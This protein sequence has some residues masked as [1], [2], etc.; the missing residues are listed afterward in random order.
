MAN[1]L[2]EYVISLTTNID[3]T[4]IQKMFSLLDSS[5]L[6]TLGVTAALAA[7]TTATYKFIESATKE[8]FRLQSLAKTQN[9]A[10][11]NVRASEEALSA[12][13]MTLNEI[14]KDKAMETIYNDLVKFN[15]EMS[16]PNMASALAKVNELRTA[17][18]KLKSA[19]SY[20]IQWVN[21][22]VLANLEEP[23]N[24]ITNKITD[25]ANWIR[26]NITKIATKVSTYITAFAKGIIGIVES[27][28][29]IVN[30]VNQIPAGIKNIMTSIGLLW[31]LIKSG[32]IGQLLTLVTMIGD[33][34]Q[35]YENYKWNQTQPEENR[36]GVAFE[37]L[38]RKLDSGDYEGIADSIIQALTKAL[39]DFTEFLS[40][41]NLDDILSDPESALSGFF[42]RITNWFNKDGATELKGLGDAFLKALGTALSFTGDVGT[43]FLSS[44]ASAFGI[45]KQEDIE[46]AF[47]KNPISTGFST[48]L[49]LS[50][51]GADPIAA[52]AGGIVSSIDKNK[53]DLGD[54]FDL[55]SDEVKAQYEGGKEQFIAEN[56]W[57]NLGINAGEL[58]EGLLGM[59]KS[60]I[61]TIDGF[62]L[63]IF[64]MIADS[65]KSD[66][67]GIL[68]SLGELISSF[69]EPIEKEVNGEVVKEA[70]TLG[71]VILNGIITSLMTGNGLAG[72]VASLA[73]LI[74]KVQTDEEWNEF[75]QECQK[76]GEAV[77]KLLF[78][79]VDE[80]TGQQRGGIVNAIVEFVS[81]LWETIGPHLEPLWEGIKNGI[82]S[83]AAGIWDL[84][85]P[86][87]SF[88]GFK[89]KGWLDDFLEKNGLIKWVAEMFGY[90][91]GGGNSWVEDEYGNVTTA[92]R[93]KQNGASD[94]EI[95]EAFK[96]GNN[97]EVVKMFNEQ[98]VEYEPG[99]A[100]AGTVYS[101]AEKAE[102]GEGVERMGAAIL[103]YLGWKNGKNQGYSELSLANET[104][105]VENVLKEKNREEE[106]EDIKERAGID[107]NGVLAPDSG[108]EERE[109]PTQGRI[110]VINKPEAEGPETE[111][112][113]ESPVQPA[114]KQLPEIPAQPEESV[115]ET[116]PEA[117]A[118][119]AKPER[120]TPKR[121]LPEIPADAEIPV[122]NF[123]TGSFQNI[124]EE[125]G[126]PEVEIE[127]D[128]SSAESEFQEFVAEIDGKEVS[129]G[130]KLNPDGSLLATDRM[131]TK[132]EYQAWLDGLFSP[133][134]AKISPTITPKVNTRQAG[135]QV[136]NF[137]NS[138]NGKS[139]DLFANIRFNWSNLF[140][141]NN[142]GDGVDGHKATGGRIP[143]RGIYELAEEAPE[144]VIPTARP[145]RAF[146]LIVQMLSE[147]GRG[148][149]Q[150][151]LDYYGS[152]TPDGSDPLGEFAGNL[153]KF[154]QSASERLKEDFGLGNAGTI[155][156]SA[157]NVESML[158]SMTQNYTYNVSA[159]VSI[160]V[161]SS[162][163]SAEDIGS[164]VYS[165]AERHLLKSLRGV[166]A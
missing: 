115:S 24:R 88:V 53:K 45:F 110:A 11:E 106:L 109:T 47:K 118:P 146:S 83:L 55:L 116:K 67:P 96:R 151:I 155:G 80:K 33:T 52:I 77:G 35:D 75:R 81:G 163:A 30:W 43:T 133:K 46:K 105:G 124:G 165:A 5:K 94:A 111:A 69:S 136:T 28:E 126:N 97:N 2:Q 13:G 17:F 74:A 144:Y 10:I 100:K 89:L 23:I 61:D 73:T 143:Y 65:L 114:A 103:D 22:Q 1:G 138:Q 66:Q 127:A 101:N 36:V 56:F 159:P 93:M 3:N 21:A 71:S 9:K 27:F 117:A 107:E 137:L 14:K 157:Q 142:D 15:K 63:S 164:S 147:M 87:L 48:G 64:N 39:T 166:F 152:M 60:A 49:I 128:T 41:I 130:V 59:V 85:S 68:S 62:G 112:P 31:G 90:T 57:K 29:K 12:M 6:K 72:I 99:I 145:D 78:G 119:E 121:Q 122:Y 98:G 91:P 140:G 139:F 129:I 135:S 51:L 25:I 161:N 160:Q 162:G 150:R 104:I 4:G 92:Q 153:A 20:A 44:L 50:F 18:W 148:M 42:E 40:G 141:G 7:A 158:Q 102:Y 125:T 79:E 76:F 120:V 84:I 149:V 131:F 95:M 26:D 123:K 37:G 58:G 8:E 38:W 108:A 34:I 132:E 82:R 54:A 32:P 134:S 113:E 16:L 19:I 156:S 154:G 70:N 86:Y